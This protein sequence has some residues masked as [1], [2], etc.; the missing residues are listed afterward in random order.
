MRDEDVE[1]VVRTAAA[2]K[3][4]DSASRDIAKD[5]IQ[6]VR[7]ARMTLGVQRARHLYEWLTWRACG[8]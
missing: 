3:D 2:V 7:T 1:R 5:Y 8:H 4:G 6:Q